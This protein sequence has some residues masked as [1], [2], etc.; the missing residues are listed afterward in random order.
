MGVN[1]SVTITPKG[2]AHCKGRLGT[3]D[4]PANSDNSL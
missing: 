4:S 1:G 2:P 3:D